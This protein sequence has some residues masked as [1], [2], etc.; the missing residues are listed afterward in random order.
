MSTTRV[1][2]SFRIDKKLFDK[3]KAFARVRG[4]NV[5]AVVEFLLEQGLI[6]AKQTHVKETVMGFAMDLE[7]LVKRN[8]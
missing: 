4:P 3:I 1:H 7:D 6:A 5:N 8:K 2:K